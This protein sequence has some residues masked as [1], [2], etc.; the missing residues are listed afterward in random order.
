MPRIFDNI[1]LQLLGALK[2]TLEVSHRADFCVGYF[3]LRGWKGLAD[4]VDAWSG[5][6]GGQARVLVGMHKTPDEELHTLYSLASSAAMIDQ[7][8][9]IRLKRKMADEFRRQLTVGAPTN[10]DEEGLRRLRLQLKEGKV[11]V[12]LFLKHSLHAKLYLAYR[13][14][15]INPIIAYLGSSNLTMAGLSHQGELNVD[16]L[17]HDACDKLRGW[18]ENRWTDKWCLDITDELADLIEESWA[19]EAVI[20]PYHVYLKMAYHLSREAQ[21]AIS[22]FSIPRVFGQRLFEFQVKA[23]QIGAHHVNRREGVLIGDVVGLGKTLMATALARIMQDDHGFETLILCPK[24][25]VKMWEDYAHTYEL[26][27]KVLSVTRA[28]Q[29][30]PDLRRYRLVLIDESHNLRNRE[31][32]RYKA[33]QEYIEKN[34]SKCILLSATPYNKSY[35]DLASQLALFVD[36]TKDL[37]IRPEAAIRAIGETEFIRR[38]QSP[39]RSLAAFEKSDEPDDWRELMR[40][41]MVRRTRSFIKDNYAEKDEASGRKFLTYEDGTRSY[42]PNRVPKTVAFKHNETDRTDPYVRMYSPD[43]VQTIAALDLPRY[44]LGKYVSAS[45]PT[46]PAEDLTLAGLGR[47]GERLI[48]FCRTNLYK[49]L[50]SGGPAFIQSVER[51]ILRNFVVLHALEHGLAVPIGTQA[52]EDLDTAYNDEDESALIGSQFGDEGE[53]DE[54]ADTGAAAG[55]RDEADFRKRAASIYETYS[56]RFKRRFKWLRAELFDRSLAAEL[57][58]D[59]QALIKVLDTCGSW[60]PGRDEKLNSL[61]DLLTAKHPGDKILVFTQ[62]A[63]TARYLSDQLEKRGVRSLEVVTGDHVDPTGVAWRFSPESNEK[64]DQIKQQD[65]LRVLVTTDVLSEGQNLQDCAIIV[66]YDIPWAIIRLVQR[67]GRVDRIGQQSDTILC[68]SFVPAAGIE[69]IIDLRGRVSRRL[70]E[71]AEV[72]GTDESFFEDDDHRPLMDLYN[73]KSGILDGEADTEV[74]LA[75]LA[76][77][78]WKNAIDEDKSLEAKIRGLPDVV[79]STKAYEPVENRPPEGVLVYM[80][81]A[82][83]NDALAW[84]NELGDSVTQSQLAVLRAAECQS[85][86]PA[87]PR[88][89]R[90]HE[91]VTAAVKHMLEEEKQV[92]GQLGRPAG[93]RFKTYERLKDYVEQVKDTLFNTPDLHKAIEDIYKF[94]L[95]Q[96]ATD[97][98]N[99]QLKAAID[100][101]TLAELVI[102][103][104]ADGRLCRI[105]EDGDDKPLEPRIICS[106]GLFREGSTGDG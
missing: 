7:Q 31:G 29:D 34:D 22:E 12:K 59:S 43:V 67:A 49:R 6:A 44:G 52:A 58:K 36:P 75:S 9:V 91:L 10:A 15:P 65:E 32:K 21:T 11:V 33:I 47:A 62:F 28:Q 14:D 81:T 17:D 88:H 101:P 97:T 50:E 38:H 90:H 99:R 73:E 71:N 42:F 80:R 94:P 105:P 54:A 57:L 8:E 82:D 48:G 93:A 100:N 61:E 27:A 37:G 24:N 87:L 45:A 53:D 103:L 92:G 84:V 86:T 74:D 78:I 35:L 63:D 3:N 72:V 66:N 2:E 16:V 70:R 95:L 56:D 89:E 85:D 55:V 60:E 41:Y 5:G 104:R 20:P 69:T 51:H 26:R 13:H 68:Y 39:V 25:L 96:S 83:D 102:Q 64:R 19:R 79:Y 46:T 98:L 4:H 77:Q 40:L 106:M 18:F 76:Y 23:V 30:L 1:D